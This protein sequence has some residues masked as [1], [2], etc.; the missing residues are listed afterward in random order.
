MLVFSKALLVGVA[1]L[2]FAGA[3]AL[4]SSKESDPAMYPRPVEDA[5]L[6]GAVLGSEE[7][8]SDEAR[9]TLWYYYSHN[10]GN[11]PGCPASACSLDAAFRLAR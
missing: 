1:G 5:G 7:L 3:A 6:N 10:L 2:T 4:I 8:I 9:N 11:Q